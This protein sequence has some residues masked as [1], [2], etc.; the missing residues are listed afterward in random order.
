M[1]SVEIDALS[2]NGVTIWNL[3]FLMVLEKCQIPIDQIDQ[4][5]LTI[6]MDMVHLC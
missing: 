2:I 5:T 4:K 6:L 1:M 3:W